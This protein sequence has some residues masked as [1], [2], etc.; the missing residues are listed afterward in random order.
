MTLTDKLKSTRLTYTFT[1]ESGYKFTVCADLTDD[2]GWTATV[3][4]SVRGMRDAESAIRYL[5]APVRHFLRMIEAD[6]EVD[7]AGKGG[8]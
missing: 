6:A 3:S 1:D 7:A 4:M 2:R 8:G 5:G